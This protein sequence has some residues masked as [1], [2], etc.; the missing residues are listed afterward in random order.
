[1]EWTP[2]QQR[3]ISAVNDWLSDSDRDPVFRLFGYAGTGK[4]TIAKAI[5]EEVTGQVFFAAFTGKAALVLNS[6]GC[7]GARTIHSL[8]YTPREK[9]AE[10][11]KKLAEELREALDADD[12]DRLREIRA[13]HDAERDNLKRPAFNLNLQSDLK[14]AALLI[15]DEVSMVDTQIGQDLL[16][17]DV[18]ILALGDPGQLPP[19]R[20]QGFFTQQQ[21][22]FLLEEIHRQAQDSPILGMAT[23][24]RTGVALS[25]GGPDDAE[26]VPRGTYDAH[27]LAQFDQV[28]CGRN[29][30]RRIVNKHIREKVMQVETPLPVPGDRIVC[31][32]NDNDSGLLN[33]SQ[34]DVH[35]VI[36]LDDDKLELLISATGE[37]ETY[38]FAVKAHK[39]FFLGTEDEIAPYEIREA[40]CFD[41]AYALTCH[42]AQGSQWNSVAIINESGCF[43][44]TSHQWLYTAVT[45][46]AE[47]VTVIQ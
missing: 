9:C 34:W 37:E 5:A 43:Q 7:F 13:L 24:A 39:Q 15:V 18:P 44:G 25:Y 19:V 3:A 20:G 46:A 42:K 35:E 40:Q 8:I 31:L 22:D 10:Q 12:E 6:K 47:K 33:G 11:L 28:I 16:S 30:T 23:K 2:E 21:P 1:M 45:R 27:G 4:T 38:T 17:F 32:R 26:V 36:D 29:K 14:G 41:Y